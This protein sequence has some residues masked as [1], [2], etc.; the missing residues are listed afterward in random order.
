MFASNHL[1]TCT[2]IHESMEAKLA[3]K[4]LR[5]QLLTVISH[6]HVTIFTVDTDRR[7]TMLEGSLSWD[8]TGE[9]YRDHDDGSRWYL[10]HNMYEVFNRLNSHLED[11]ERPPFLEPVESILAGRSTEDIQEHGIGR[12]PT[13]TPSHSDDP[14]PRADRL[15]PKLRW[16]LVP[17]SLHPGHREDQD[18]VRLYGP[19]RRHRGCYR[20][21]F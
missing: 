7:V 14:T 5:E 6:A 4:R 13:L 11:G 12:R 20:R 16:S 21:H 9:R 1:G 8:A 19:R 15:F 17:D 3:A 2:D 18:C 10:G